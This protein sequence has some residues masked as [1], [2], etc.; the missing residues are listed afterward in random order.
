MHMRTMEAAREVEP[1]PE[2]VNM[3]PLLEGSQSRM[4][5]EQSELQGSV[6]EKREACRFNSAAESSTCTHLIEAKLLEH[7]VPSDAQRWQ[8]AGVKGRCEVKVTRECMEL[9]HSQCLHMQTPQEVDQTR[10]MAECKG[11]L[12]A[13]TS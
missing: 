9:I 13:R 4:R 10:H 12:C 8:D 7:P 11:Q 1:S 6:R 3:K 2:E 5:V